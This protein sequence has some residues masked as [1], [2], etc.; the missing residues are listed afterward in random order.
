MLQI[1]LEVSEIPT[2]ADYVEKVLTERDPEQGVDEEFKSKLNP[3]FCWKY[4]RSIT[5]SDLKKI[6]KEKETQKD[7]GLKG[8]KEKTVEQKR[9]QLE[10]DDIA[11]LFI[12]DKRFCLKEIIEVIEP[13]KQPEQEPVKEQKE[14]EKIQI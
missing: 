9:Y 10:V 14:I 13:E 3:T 12:K 5:T 6:E 8:N 2:T 7:T 4:Y 11:K 1:Q